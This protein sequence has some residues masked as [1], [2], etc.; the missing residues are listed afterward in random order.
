MSK[1][2]QVLKSGEKILFGI[3]VVFIGLAVIAYAALETYRMSRTEPMFVNKT[4]YNFSEEGQ[5]GSVIFRKSGC[6]ACHRALR[7]GTNMGLSLDGVGSLRS[8]DWLVGFLADPEKT[9][10]AK[11]FDH[12]PSPK[13]AAYVA[14]MPEKDRHAMAVFISELKSDQGSSSAPVPPEGR[15]DFID[16]MVGAWAPTEWKER[17]TDVRTK[18]PENPPADN[19]ESTTPSPADMADKPQESSSEQ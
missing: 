9:Y 17:Y 14:E 16:K 8:L 19:P 5:L 6:T 12:G 15:S 11:T 1:E 18:P 4:H 7:N 13:E 10:G 3:V 2:K